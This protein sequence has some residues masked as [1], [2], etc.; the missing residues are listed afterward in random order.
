MNVTKRT[1]LC[2]MYLGVKSVQNQKCISTS[3]QHFSK[4]S[5]KWRQSGQFLLVVLTYDGPWLHDLE[6]KQCVDHFCCQ[7]HPRYTRPWQ[8]IISRL[9]SIV[10]CKS[11]PP[12]LLYCPKLENKKPFF[13][14]FLYRLFVSSETMSCYA[15]GVRNNCFRRV[16]NIFVLDKNSSTW[17]RQDPFLCPLSNLNLIAV[18]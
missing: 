12:E 11:S 6:N 17:R 7:H 18:V 9:L 8:H 13:W 2:F 10:L 15:A 5:G 14:L 3:L 4:T 1:Y 16:S